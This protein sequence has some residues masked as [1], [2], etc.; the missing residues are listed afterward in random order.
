MNVCFTWIFMVQASVEDIF[1]QSITNKYLLFKF[2]IV[3]ICEKE[4]KRKLL[5][6]CNIKW[7]STEISLYYNLSHW[8]IFYHQH[9]HKVSE[10]VLIMLC[11]VKCSI[12]REH[13]AII[14]P[15]ASRK[16]T[17]QSISIY[18]QGQIY[19]KLYSSGRTSMLCLGVNEDDRLVLNYV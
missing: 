8:F 12:L 13:M 1:Q 15:R 5:K 4:S 16:Q 9:C 7:P 11:K 14:S 6:K 17:L 2:I 3:L 18:C 19:N 10:T